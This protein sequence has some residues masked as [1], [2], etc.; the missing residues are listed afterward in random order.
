VFDSDCGAVSTVTWAAEAFPLSLAG[1]GVVS[2]NSLP[3]GWGFDSGP[4]GEQKGQ[5]MAKSDFVDWCYRRKREA[6]AQ[7]SSPEDLRSTLL[8][9]SKRPLTRNRAPWNDRD[10]AFESAECRL[11]AR[12]QLVHR[13]FFSDCHT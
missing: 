10:R 11:T 2:V 8:C 1:L 4:A 3:L 7:L 12:L 13:C 5:R 9:N 6:N